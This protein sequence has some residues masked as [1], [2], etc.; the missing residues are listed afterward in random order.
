MT[1]RAQ[2]GIDRLT[3][4]V[5][6]KS[7]RFAFLGILVSLCFASHVGAQEW[8]Y[9]GGDEGG[10]RFSPLTQV[11][12]E[13]VSRLQ[14]AWTYH[15]GE[16][17]RDGN[18]TDR[19]RVAPFESTPLVVDG[20]LYFSTPSNRVIALDSESGKEIWQFDP[21]A[22]QAGQRKF[23]QH[24]GV[25]YWESAGGDDRRILYG[26]FDGRLIALNAKTGK[27]C[28]DFG[29]NGTINLRVGVADPYPSSLYSVTSPPAIY[30]ALEISGA[31]V[32][33][34]PSK[35]PRG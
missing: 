14:R 34:Y 7:K 20:V 8:P 19:H 13:N 9:Y 22:G 17:E 5:A 26:T 30:Q 11:S 27:L 12:R 25:A 3:V 15:T 35:G 18:A 21:Q 33:E 6:A 2:S 4:L 24:R 31:E 10:T 32:T 1:E 23:F 16:V 28:A 29:S